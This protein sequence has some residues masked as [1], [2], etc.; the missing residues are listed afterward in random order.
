MI[1][2]ITA[3]GC[4]SPSEA[5]RICKRILT[6]GAQIFSELQVN[7]LP[8]MRES[9]IFVHDKQIR[10][11]I[12]GVAIDGHLEVIESPFL[13]GDPPRDRWQADEVQTCALFADDSTENPT[14]EFVRAESSAEVD[15]RFLGRF[16]A[17]PTRP[18][19]VKL[20]STCGDGYSASSKEVIVETT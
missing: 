9:L 10:R 4:F 1:I 15:D 20:V 13:L 7:N 6:G 8:V 14:H 17:T 18:I 19:V 3:L 2:G 5:W 12:G 16:Q 11:G